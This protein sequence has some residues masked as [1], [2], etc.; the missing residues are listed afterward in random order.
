[1]ISGRNIKTQNTLFTSTQKYLNWFTFFSV[2]PLI[3]IA[4][5]SI[6]FPLFIMI[7]FI[8]LKKGKKLFRITQWTDLFLVLFLT[9][10]FISWILQ[11]ETF[12]DRSLFSIF[13]L[14]VQYSYW[15]TVALFIKTWIY[16]Y[17]FYKISR[18]IFWAVVA[19]TLYYVFLNPVHFIFAPNEYAYAV[20]VAMPI[21]YYYVMRRFSSTV[22]LLISAGIVLGVLYS[23]SRA[24]TTLTLFEIV[25][26]L[27]LGKKSMKKFTMIALL[28]MVPLTPVAWVVL[29]KSN[30]TSI[31]YQV[32][33]MLEDYSPK[34]AYTLRME[35]N[36]FDRD[37]SWLIRE[38]MWQKGKL[39]FEKHPFF[40]VGP[41]NFTKYYADIN[42]AEV[43]SWLNTRSIEG[44]NRVSSQNSYLMIL[45]E[46][47]V[48]ALASILIVFFIILV[49]GFYYLR[50]LKDNAEIYIYI[51]F[52]ATLAY[53]IILVT[54]MGTLFWFVLGLALTL[55]Q[56]KRHLS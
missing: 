12:R 25:L 46:N 37:K 17:D 48:F 24:G 16:E 3:K 56:R 29:D 47:G 21:G 30:I 34:I 15:V 27:G 5:M 28:L 43:S 8:Y 22:V 10:V 23:G 55:T 41:G 19:S 38:L 11:E 40:G 39:I 4:G 6:T 35:E 13:K 33:D 18:S 26:L 32:A 51:P 52:I 1:M 50:T 9:F 44:Y 53:S 7:A 36:V 14:M 42:P 20:V 54:T 45:A 49:K 31:K 2:F